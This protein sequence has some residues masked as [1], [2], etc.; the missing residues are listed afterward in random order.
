[1]E[2]G[3]SKGQGDHGRCRANYRCCLP[4]LA[5]FV[6]P[7]SVGPG[8]S[9]S[10]PTL[11]P[12]QEELAPDG[13]RAVRRSKS[14][15][16]RCKPADA[17]SE[18]IRKGARGSRAHSRTGPEVHDTPSRASTPG[19]H[20]PGCRSARSGSAVPDPIPLAFALADPAVALCTGSPI[21]ARISLISPAGLPI[22]LPKSAPSLV[23]PTHVFQCAANATPLPLV[24]ATSCPK[25]SVSL[26]R[27]WVSLKAHGHQTKALTARSTPGE[28]PRKLQR[29][30]LARAKHG[31]PL[32]AC[33]T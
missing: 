2:T 11:P 20:L 26:T 9:H 25:S 30:V 27:G 18:G 32:A 12:L 1:V 29:Q 8:A 3:N 10:A 5:G 19:V 17:E 31:G 24:H 28:P 21:G 23:R 16:I 13:K 15:W 4:A 14:A 6:C 33:R 7:H 22:Q